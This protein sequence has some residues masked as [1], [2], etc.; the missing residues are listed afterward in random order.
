MRT[1]DVF[2]SKVFKICPCHLG[3]VIS[4][5]TTLHALVSICPVRLFIFV[6]YYVLRLYGQGRSSFPLFQIHYY[7][8]YHLSVHV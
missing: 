8:V 6:Y 1:G 2:F 7:T 3:V 5:I 4:R